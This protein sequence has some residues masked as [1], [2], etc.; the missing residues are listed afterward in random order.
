MSDSSSQSQNTA[1]KKA[2]LGR[3]LGSLLGGGMDIHDETPTQAFGPVSSST[4]LPVAATPVNASAPVVVTQKIDEQAQIWQIPIDRLEP[5]TQQPRHY[6]SPEALR[7]LTASIQ[8][9]GILQPIVARRKD[10]RTFEIIA[11]ERRWRA[12]QLAGLHEVPVILKKVDEQKSLEL[13][14]IENIQRQDLNILEEAEAYDRLMIDYRLTQQQVAEK[15]GKE[16]ATVANA[17]RLLSLPIEL[18]ELVK[19]SALSAGHAKVIL[20]VEDPLDQIK[21]GKK[22]VADKLSV[23]ATEQLVAQA[24]KSMSHAAMGGSSPLNLDVSKRLVTALAAELQKLI[25]TKVTIDYAD[26]KGK[27]SVYFYSDE[28]LNQITDKIRDAWQK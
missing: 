25:G 20:A 14:I 11:G 16:R 21:I 27:F 6:F 7:D 18:K 2:R 5:N 12:A 13:A 26:A 24:K 22:V 1:N 17:L 4:V 9:Q 19:S 3:G 10:D 23:R 28:E 15:V 8:E